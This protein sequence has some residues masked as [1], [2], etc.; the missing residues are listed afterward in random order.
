MRIRAAIQKHAATIIIAACAG[1]LG[2]VAHDWIEAAQGTIRARR[3]EITDAGGRTMSYWGPEHSSIGSRGVHLVFME[4]GVQRC[5]IGTGYGPGLEFYGKEGP[6]EGKR[7]RFAVRL[8]YGDDAALTMADAS[9]QRVF[10]GATHGDAPDQS[11]DQWALWLRAREERAGAN[12][13]FFRWWDGSYQAGVTLSDESGRKWEA[14]TP[15]K[16]KPLPLRLTAR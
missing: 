10:L 16:L 1:F 12:I 3:F 4:N 15:G 11:E 13:G 14:V 8:H 2:S 9:G 5:R 6:S 7:P